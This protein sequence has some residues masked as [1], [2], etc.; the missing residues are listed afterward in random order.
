MTYFLSFGGVSAE[1]YTQPAVRDCTGGKLSKIDALGPSVATTTARAAMRSPVRR[2]TIVPSSDSTGE[3]R[4][5]VFCVSRE[6][7][8][9]GSAC[10][11]RAG[12]TLWPSLSER[13]IMSN[14]RRDVANCGSSWTPPKS[15]LKN[16]SIM[17]CEKPALRSASSVDMSALRNN[18][19]ATPRNTRSRNSTMRNLS[20]TV[21]IGA[22]VVASS[23]EGLRN[24]SETTWPFPPPPFFDWI[25]TNAPGS[26]ACRSS[27]FM[28][29]C[30]ASSGYAVSKT[31]NPRSSKN[32]STLSVRTRP[33]MPSD[34]SSITTLNPLC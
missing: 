26:N 8:C 23:V 34:A 18:L 16:V 30:V 2:V 19:G 3:L 21:P 9:S 28:S 24:G 6:A 7:S 25:Q 1:K 15:G 22:N 11:P 4:R 14:M 32:P 12:N 33:P 31:W 29:T 20:I 27:A 17:R 10:M 13:K 5:T